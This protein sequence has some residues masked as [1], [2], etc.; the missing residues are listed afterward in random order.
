MAATAEATASRSAERP[1]RVVIAGITLLLMRRV[2][3]Q[4]HETSGA[5]SHERR[6]VLEKLSPV[7]FSFSS[8][9]ERLLSGYSLT[10]ILSA[11]SLLLCFGY[12]T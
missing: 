4:R 3:C 6:A 2:L 12:F 10:P 1:T 9:V 5:Y 7:Q 11:R 8:F